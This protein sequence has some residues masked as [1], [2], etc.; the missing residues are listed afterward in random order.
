MSDSQ[1]SP[2]N[3]HFEQEL[4]VIKGSI[5]LMRDIKF[6]FYHFT[7]F[8]GTVDVILHLLKGQWT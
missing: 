3:L 2:L 7:S 8:K 6:S 4:L 1:L 5:Y